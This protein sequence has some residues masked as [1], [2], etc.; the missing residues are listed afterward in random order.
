M[1][2]TRW[3][4]QGKALREPRRR[5]LQHTATPRN[6]MPKRLREQAEADER[7]RHAEAL[8]QQAEA[9]GRVTGLDDR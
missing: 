3:R 7:K 9:D 8:K 5:R 6:C 1:N 2:P 4:E